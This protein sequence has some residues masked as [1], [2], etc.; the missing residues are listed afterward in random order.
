MGLKFC[1]IA[2]GSTGNCYFIQSKETLLLIDVGISG[3][4]IIEGLADIGIHPED[5][6]GI[7]LTHEHVDH[8]KSVR[9]M[10]KKSSNASL[11][12]NIGTWGFVKDKVAEDR[13]VLFQTGQW[14]TVGDI[15]IHPFALCHDAEDP[16]GFTLCHGG[17]T[18]TILT[19]T[20]CITP[21]IVHAGQDA[22]LLVLEANHDEEI[23]K[24]CSYPY[25]I[26]KRILSDRGHLSNEAAADFL[27]QIMKKKEKPRQVLLAHLSKENNTPHIARLTVENKLEQ[28]GLKGELLLDIRVL[29]PKEN[30]SVFIIE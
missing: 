26:K 5:L 11:Y 23:L 15:D 12:T 20:G 18:V 22:D 25:E 13:Q 27:C 9:I 21:S 8:S 17:K 3:K 10:M 1:A 4:K 24:F 29:S 6:K 28:E 16:V 14:F 2:S 30:S 7:L 19:D